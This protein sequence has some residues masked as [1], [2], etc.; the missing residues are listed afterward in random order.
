M[1][2]WP[3]AGRSISNRRKP[4]DSDRDVPSCVVAYSYP[5]KTS[6]F[7]CRAFFSACGECTF[8]DDD[9]LLVR[10]SAVLKSQEP[11]ARRMRFL[12]FAA[13]KQTAFLPQKTGFC[14]AQTCFGRAP[15]GFDW[16]T[17]GLIPRGGGCTGGWEKRAII[18]ITTIKMRYKNYSWHR[19]SNQQELR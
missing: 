6:R 19:R 10:A 3:W 8:C 4:S 18:I 7:S 9:E 13:G 14:A 16:R 11:G 17:L 5:P 12:W 15:R 1:V 2:Q